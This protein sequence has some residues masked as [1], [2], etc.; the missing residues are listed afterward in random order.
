MRTVSKVIA[1]II[2]LAIVACGGDKNI[3]GKKAKIEKLKAQQIS[4]ADEIKTLE[5]EIANSGDTSKKLEKM[6]DVMTTKLQPQIFSHSIDV[7]GR[8]EGDE[9]ITIS[10]KMAGTI[11]KMN[12]VA[13][14]QVSAGQV[15]AEIE[16]EVMRA[17]LADMKSSYELLKDIYNRQKSLWDQKVGTE[18][19]YLQAKNN[20]ESMEQ[21]IK[22]LTETLDMY[23]IKAPFSGTVDEVSI[24]LG[25][26]VA[27]GMPAVRLVNFN[28]L[29]VRADLA[30]AYSGNV[31]IGDVVNLKFPDINK[32]ETSKVS[33]NGKVINTM[34]RTFN[35]EIALPSS[36]VYR[37]NMVA[38]VSIVDYT[39]KDAITVPVNTIQNI[40]DKNYVYVASVKNGKNIASK[41]EV[42]VGSTYNGTAEITSGLQTGDLVITT[43]YSNLNDGEL[44][45]Y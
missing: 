35:V 26:T 44:I 23:N 5:Q 7:Q 25:Q 18:I 37:P 11:T 8:V 14:S 43:G 45:K 38:Q 34:T 13:G 36:D 33:Y 29:K 2:L 12:V 4:I 40:D 32:S 3:E 39:N 15:L 42:V 28:K 20:K 30:E 24:K 17:Q 16:S 10:T 31:K 21:K 27:P 22:Q 41:R 19:Q 6:K 9:N 1:S